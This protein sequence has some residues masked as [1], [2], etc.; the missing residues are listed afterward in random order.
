MA[1]AA[2]LK[3]SSFD[4]KMNSSTFATKDNDFAKA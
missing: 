1:L 3:N 2:I 4:E